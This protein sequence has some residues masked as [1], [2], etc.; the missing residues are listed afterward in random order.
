ML[1]L[2][3]YDPS[4]LLFLTPNYPT[5]LLPGLRIVALLNT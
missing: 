5:A 3:Q 1:V 2:K 4:I